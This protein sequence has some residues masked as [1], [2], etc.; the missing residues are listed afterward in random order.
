MGFGRKMLR[1]S[2]SVVAVLAMSATAYAADA[3]APAADSSLD[4]IVV[5]GFRKSIQDSIDVKRDKTAVVDVVSAEDIGKLP[6]KNVADALQRVPGVMIQSAASG[7]GGFDEADRVSIRGSSP[8]LTNT[9]ING[10]GVA[11]GDWFLLDQFSTVGRSVSFSLLPSEIVDKTLVYKSQQ[12]D[13][14]EGG[15]AGSIDILTRKPLDFKDNFTAAADIEGVYGDM[16]EKVSPQFNGLVSWKNKSNTFGV[17]AQAFYEE[18][19]VQREGQE[20]LGYSQFAATDAAV[21]AHPELN[22]VYYPTLIGSALFQQKRKRMGGDIDVE[23]TP[24][25]KLTVDIN[26]FYSHM[27]ADNSNRNFMYWGSSIFSTQQAVPTAYT[28]KNNTLTSATTPSVTNAIVYDQ[29]SRPGASAETSY[30]DADVT[31]QATDRLSFTGKVGYT[32]GLGDTPSEPAY[33]AV[34]AS[35]ASYALNGLSAPATVNFGIPTGTQNGN[36]ATGWAWTDV[37]TAV[38]QEYYGQLDAKYDVKSGIWDSV[39]AGVRVSAHQRNTQFKV[40]GGC[41]A[42]GGWGVATPSSSGTYP[43]GFGSNLGGPVLTNIWTLSNDQIAA[44]F[45]SYGIGN[46]DPINGADG[47]SRYYWPGSFKVSE[48]DSAAYVMANVGG[49]GWSGNFGVRFVDTNLTSLV[50]FASTA[51]APGAINTSA[52]GPYVPTNISHDYVN[53]LPSAN[54][55]LEVTDD[56]VAHLAVAKTMARPDYSALGGSV[57]LNDVASSGSGGNPDLKPI[58]STNYDA[59]LEWYYGPQSLLSFA[60]FYNDMNSYVTYGVTPQTFYSDFY[61]AN[62]TYQVTHPFN[63]SAKNRG[64]E[65]AIQQPI[66]GGFGV[67]ANY[68]YAYGTEESGAPM[69]GNSRHTYNLTGYYENDWI[70]AHLSYTFRSHFV[71]GLDRSTLEN[72]DDFG[73]LDASVNIPV[74]DYLSLTF[75]ALNITDELM[76]YYANNTDQPRAIYDNGRQYYFGAH[77]KY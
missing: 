45:N 42:N 56:V 65:L 47:T 31:Y 67:Q 30:I 57:S 50:Y 29:I 49:A 17:L 36:Y 77:F 61:K 66:Y 12:A 8:S 46:A 6:D 4:E 28:V 76:K 32:Y 39:K 1:G 48:T 21:K 18:R 74:N 58:E 33:E 55:K 7:E 64:F 9:T 35:S 69:I 10:H 5:T 41:C 62:H 24:T 25:D 37:L 34:A 16:A 23:F 2:A 11:T 38:D 73:T 27:D 40:D 19:D 26:G 59:S 53:V 71:V 70:S 3:P 43:A 72:Q 60:V 15:V 52:F 75:S 54:L 22:G 13:L 20:V 63:T 14:V 51:G 68:T 44:F